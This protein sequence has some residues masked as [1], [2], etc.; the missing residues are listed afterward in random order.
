M[1]FLRFFSQTD[2]RPTMMSMD[3]FFFIFN[4]PIFNISG[5]NSIY[6][7][8]QKQSLYIL[9]SKRKEPYINIKNKYQMFPNKTLALTKPPKVRNLAKAIQLGCQCIFNVWWNVI[10]GNIN[11]FWLTLDCRWNYWCDNMIHD[12]L[13]SFLSL[14]TR[15]RR[16]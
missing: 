8:Y 15:S 7:E 16:K 5:K 13:N 4:S 11:R 6:N 14:V 2:G 3:I 10:T 1:L 12:D 9:D